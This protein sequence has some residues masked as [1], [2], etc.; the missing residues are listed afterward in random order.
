[1]VMKIGVRPRE[2]GRATIVTT[3]CAGMQSSGYMRGVTPK[4]LLLQ[5]MSAVD[6]PLEVAILVRAGALFGHAPGSVRV[7][8]SRLAA[9]GHVVQVTRG[10]WRLGPTAARLAGQV[11]TW[12]ELPA[13][14]RPWEGAWIGVATGG[15]PRT[16][17]AV[18]ARRDRALSLLGF[19]ALRPGLEVRPDNRVDGV[20]GARERLGALGLEADAPVLAIGP[21]GASEAEARALWDG[22]A[23]EAGYREAGA[24]IDRAAARMDDLDPEAAARD[25]F[26]A[27]GAAIRVLAFDPLLP[28]PI[29]DPAPRWALVDQLRRFDARARTVWQRLW[30]EVA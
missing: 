10:R 16:D 12:R 9:G 25:V 11:A 4:S 24:A 19:R 27:G 20:A 29:V 17:R 14:V 2:V 8:L 21:L 18:T 30:E 13:L 5:L 15:L 26:L 1:M 28:A 7:A 6:E 23:L 3:D 22:A